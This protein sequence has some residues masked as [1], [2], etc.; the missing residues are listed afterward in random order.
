LTA[1][2]CPTASTI[3]GSISTMSTRSISGMDASQPPVVPVPSPTTSARRGLGCSSAP[4]M[5]LIT[6]VPAST[7]AWPSDLPFTISAC[8]S[9]DDSA[10][11]LS[12][13]SA[14]HV[15]ARRRKRR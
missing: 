6:C 11:L 7:R 1:A 2:K 14:C 12:R 3:A 15:T 8:P 10:T 4:S 9:S 5:P 13:P